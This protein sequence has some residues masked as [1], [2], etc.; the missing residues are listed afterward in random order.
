MP[1]PR[2][3]D[4]LDPAN[5]AGSVWADS[6]YRSRKNEDLLKERMLTSHIHR[7]KPAK[8]PMPDRTAKANAKRSA[9][10]AHVEHV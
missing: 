9:V 3:A 7:K 4:L 10:R 1:G 2:L 5:T 8:R 6:A